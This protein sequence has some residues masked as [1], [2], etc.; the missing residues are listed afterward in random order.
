MIDTSKITLQLEQGPRSSRLTLRH[1]EELSED[2]IAALL[3]DAGLRIIKKQLG[4]TDHGLGEGGS[5]TDLCE[6]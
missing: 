2:M 3:I 5:D 1:E 4:F 6:V